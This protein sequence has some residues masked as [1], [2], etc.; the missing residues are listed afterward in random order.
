L[1]VVKTFLSRPRCQDQDQDQDIIFCPRAR[2]AS[3]T[4]VLMTTSFTGKCQIPSKRRT[5]GRTNEEIGDASLRPSVRP[6]VRLSLC[7]LCLSRG[8]I[9][10]GNKPRCFKFNKKN[11]FKKFKGRGI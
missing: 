4:L 1:K 7:P 2:G 6:S 10:W 5:D 8:S 3:M 11:K 9:L